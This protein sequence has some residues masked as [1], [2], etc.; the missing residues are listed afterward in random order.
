M[1]VQRGI[2]RLVIGFI[3]SMVL[4]TIAWLMGWL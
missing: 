2:G 4:V 1:D 3:L